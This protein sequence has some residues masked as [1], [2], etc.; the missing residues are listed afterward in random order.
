MPKGAALHLHSDSMVD[1][2]WLVANATYDNSLHMCGELE[3]RNAT[4]TFRFFNSPAAAPPCAQATGWRQVTALRSDE[5]NGP[6]AFDGRL[7]N[8]LTLGHDPAAYPTKAAVW[9]QFESALSAV[10]GIIFYDPV[11]TR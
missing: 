5:K 6:A 10:D 7:V 8:A 3:S 1:V 2:A 4:L 11:H 9:Q